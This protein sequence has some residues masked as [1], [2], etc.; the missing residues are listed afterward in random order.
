MNEHY[1]L[2]PFWATKMTHGKNDTCPDRF[3]PNKDRS[4]SNVR[5]CSLKSAVFLRRWMCSNLGLGCGKKCFATVFRDDAIPDPNATWK[6]RS[7]RST[8]WDDCEQLPLRV[9]NHGSESWQWA[10][11]RLERIFP[12]K[13]QFLRLYPA[14]H[15]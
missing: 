10:I 6:R 4:E 9:L 3:L 15:V 5:P 14:N 2:L 11:L 12:L 8:E 7:S 1:E 13:C